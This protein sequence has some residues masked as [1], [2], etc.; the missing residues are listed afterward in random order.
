MPFLLSMFWRSPK[1][2]LTSLLFFSIVSGPRN[3]SNT[4]GLA[5]LDLCCCT[6]YVELAKNVFKRVL[7]QIGFVWQRRKW[8]MIPTRDAASDIWC[9]IMSQV[10]LSWEWYY[11]VIL[12][13]DEAHSTGSD[14]CSLVQ[15]C[16]NDPWILRAS[17]A[18]AL[19]LA[20][21]RSWPQCLRIYGCDSFEVF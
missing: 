8:K 5:S 21:S 14:H 16:S 2:G 15:G 17:F 19:L 3:E 7:R 4:K 10:A 13:C 18:S 12:Y 1:R 6:V 20:T 11:E 9:I